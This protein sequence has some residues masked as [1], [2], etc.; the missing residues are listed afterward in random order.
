VTFTNCRYAGVRADLN[1]VLLATSGIET[2][3]T[4][5]ELIELLNLCRGADRIPGDMAEVGVYR[6][7]SAAVMLSAG[8]KAVHLFDTF[9]GLPCS[10]D[11]LRAGHF[12]AKAAGVAHTLRRWHSRVA[13]YEGVFPRDTAHRVS[14]VRFA[15]VRLDV[16]L[17]QYTHDSLKFFWPRM[18]PGGAVVVHDYRYLPGVRRAVD[19]FFARE[20]AFLVP[21]ATN[22]CVAFR[23]PPPG[24][25]GESEAI[26]IPV[27][28]PLAG[29]CRTR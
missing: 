4:P 9:S 16:D 26:S 1:A 15:L 7:G 13:I 5:H 23:L 10:G 29:S 3:T 20:S 28:T 19:E 2:L 11:H 25:P 18:S 27:S 14:D 6:G 21:L 22:Q 12:S 8:N 17:Y 24:G